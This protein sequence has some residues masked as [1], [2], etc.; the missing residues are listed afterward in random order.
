MLCAGSA[1]TLR[2][3]GEE[4]QDLPELRAH[5]TEDGKGE[6]RKEQ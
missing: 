1:L 4:N 2:D 5:V 3:S 6:N